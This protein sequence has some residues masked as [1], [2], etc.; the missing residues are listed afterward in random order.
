MARRAW[1]KLIGFL[2]GIGIIAGTLH[3]LNIN[4]MGL[5]PHQ[6]RTY[7]LSFGWWAPVIYML[8]YAQPLVPLPVTVMSMAGGLAFGMIGG[9]A[10]GLVAATI[11][12]CGQFL[13]ARTFGREAVETMLKGRFATWDQWVGRHAFRTVFLARIVPNVPYDLQ[14]M[15]LGLSRVAFRTFTVATFLG[16]IPGIC[17]WV[18]LGHA[19]TASTQ[20]WKIVVGL[21][22]VTVLS[23]LLLRYRRRHVSV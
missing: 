9:V 14:N 8:V 21:I 2:V 6:I 13:I 22:G 3:L 16:L 20:I 12:G 1:W 18:Y 17:L 7:V 5:Q 23:S 4:P 10:T 19:L 11:R 15:S